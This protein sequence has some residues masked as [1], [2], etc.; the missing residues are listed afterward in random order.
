MKETQLKKLACCC[1]PEYMQRNIPNFCCSSYSSHLFI[2][3]G[4]VID[5]TKSLL[6]STN[7]A[8]MFAVFIQNICN[9]INQSFVFDLRQIVFFKTSFMMQHHVFE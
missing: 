3:L 7:F 2:D 8:H 9:G 6:L 1:F 5:E 4:H